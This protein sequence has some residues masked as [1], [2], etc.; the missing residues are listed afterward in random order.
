MNILVIAAH[1]DDIEPQMGGTIAK[2]IHQGHK[3]IMVL[4][5]QTGG[6][7]KH[8]RNK[9][10]ENAAKILGAELL[11][12]NYSQDDFAYN[13]A[14]I[15]VI[16]ELIKKYNPREIFTMANTDSHQDHKIVSKSVVSSCRKNNIDLYFFETVIPGGIAIEEEKYNYFVDITETME[17]K[18]KS[19]KAHESQVEKFGIGWLEAI[20]GR[21]KFRGFQMNA[22][23]AEAFTVGKIFD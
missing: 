11:Q 15:C 4:L 23:Y 16:D 10:A 12:L 13:R 5:T 7:I 1:P 20:E 9:E 3:V 14:L 18:M 17:L 21:S 19:V 6:E 22:K 8:I 2:R